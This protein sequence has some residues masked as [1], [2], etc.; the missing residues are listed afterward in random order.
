MV[1]TRSHPT[2]FPAPDLSP[3]S[4]S[5]SLSHKRWAHSPTPLTL[6]WLLISL[7]LVF[8]DSGYVLFRPHTMPGG[9]WQ[10]PLY[11]PYA[12]YGSVDYTY[13][14]PAWTSRNGFTGAQASM[15]VLESLGYC[16][17]LWIVWKYGEGK[18]RYVGGGWG[19]L[20]CLFGFSLSLV[21]FAKTLLYGTSFCPAPRCVMSKARIS[22]CVKINLL[23]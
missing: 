3:L 17:Y 16:G 4:K 11:T 10:R 23:R 22:M 14:W 19:G 21:T 15:N 6:A 20:A 8:W 5:R 18:Q 2:N 12:L 7:P 13:G 1:S 9:K